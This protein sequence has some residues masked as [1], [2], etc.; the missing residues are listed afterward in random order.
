MSLFESGIIE[1]GG[2][3]LRYQTE[4]KGPSTLVIGSSVYYPRSFS[5]NLREH[6]RLTFIDWRGF[7]ESLLDENNDQVTLDTLL[8]DIELIRQKL[9]I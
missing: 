5:K 2:F 7:S 8:D 9:E 6:L 1:I 3:K 4:G